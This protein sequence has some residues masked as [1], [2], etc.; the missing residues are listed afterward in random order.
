[1]ESIGGLKEEF[2]DKYLFAEDLSGKAITLTIGAINKDLLVTSKGKKNGIIL[3]FVGA[4]KLLVLN[5]T[6]ACLINEIFPVAKSLREWVGKRITIYPTKCQLGGETVDCIRVWGSPELKADKEVTVKAGLKK[7]QMKLH[8]VKAG[9]EPKMAPDIAE[10][11]SS[12]GEAKGANPE[13]KG[14]VSETLPD[15]DP[16]IIQAWSVLGWSREHGHAN[17]AEYKGADYPGHLSALVDKMVSE[18]G[19][20]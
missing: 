14:P 8:A 2:P 16:A 9:A 7:V 12:P 3:T 20:A 1:M 11:A 15:P 6:N 4:K 13:T 17:M 5:K 18:E 19:A 10:T